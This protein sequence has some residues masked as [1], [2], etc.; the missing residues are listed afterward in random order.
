MYEITVSLKTERSHIELFRKNCLSI[1]R[2]R[3]DGGQSVGYDKRGGGRFP[4]EVRVGPTCKRGG[5][6]VIGLFVISG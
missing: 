1:S 6:L 5:G 4:R 2:V 3:V